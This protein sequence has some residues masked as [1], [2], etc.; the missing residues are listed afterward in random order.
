MPLKILLVR[1]KPDF[2]DMILGIPIGLTMI[3]AVAEKS[4]HEVE[5]LDL[6][7]E[8]SVE[9]ADRRLRSRL[10]EQAYDLAGLSCM[11]VE[12]PGACKAAHTIRELQPSC[13]IVF[14]GQHPT[15]QPNEVAAQSFCDLVVIGEAE[16]TFSQLL[17]AL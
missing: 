2:M 6:A 16:E 14:G 12:Y 15:I 4:G 17:D 10:R 13:R 9:A 3:G 11:T 5:I 7:L 1:A 8:P